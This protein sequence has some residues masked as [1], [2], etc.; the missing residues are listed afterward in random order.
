[1]INLIN[2]GGKRMLLMGFLNMSS[3]LL[4]CIILTVLRSNYVSV[5]DYD[6]GLQQVLVS[7]GGRLLDTDHMIDMMDDHNN[8][9][10]NFI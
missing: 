6:P 2:C 5:W 1:M 10:S 8:T 4:H 7:M 3:L 9:V